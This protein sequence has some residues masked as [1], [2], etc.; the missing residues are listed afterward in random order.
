MLSPSEAT[1]SF[2]HDAFGQPRHKAVRKWATSAAHDI[3]LP[4]R[5]RL[6][7]A[8]MRQLAD[9]KCISETELSAGLSSLMVRLRIE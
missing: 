2:G 6:C 3:K 5:D 8:A 1:T 7:I 9:S 4:S